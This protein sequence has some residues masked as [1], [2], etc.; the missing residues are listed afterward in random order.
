MAAKN[1]ERQ[2]S[3]IVLLLSA[4]QP[5]N[6]ARIRR[7]VDGYAG[8]SDAAFEQS[9]E[10][11]KRAL[12]EMNLPLE[13]SRTGDEEGYRIPRGEFAL[14]PVDL[15]PAEA[16]AV[17]LAGRSWRQAGMA[18]SS[19]RA[20]MKLRAIGADPDPG[21]M[22][23]LSA[24]AEVAETRPDASRELAVLRDAI[25]ARRTVAFAYPDGHSR[26]E[27]AR[28]TRHV[29]PWSVRLVH[30]QWYLIGAD[31]DRHASR[32]FKLARIHGRVSAGARRGAFPEPD[33][34]EVAR[35]AAD[36]PG[37]TADRTAVVALRLGRELALQR[38]LQPADDPP[39]PAG[40]RAWRVAY[41]Y[42]EAFVGE[43]AALG[44]DALVLDPPELRAQVIAHLSAIVEAGRGSGK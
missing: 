23:S 10:R 30:G 21:L 15:T 18:A 38:T 40:F 43:V 41:A 19:Q 9:F 8:L 1:A 34:A 42:P 32:C 11:D 35:R 7:L 24:P 26:D 22:A 36:I 17:A 33:P 3:L 29:E 13:V 44:A 4:S 20:L 16:A 6:R 27:P 2:I 25:A 31:R 14:A 12:R 5:L 28:R 39:A 37:R